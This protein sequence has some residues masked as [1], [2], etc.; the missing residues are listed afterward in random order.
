MSFFGKLKAKLFRSS[1]KL[2]K[3]ID[4]LIEEK[5]EKSEE[6]DTVQI[7]DKTKT[8]G[9]INEQNDKDIIIEK[10]SSSIE[11]NSKEKKKKSFFKKIIEPVRKLVKK[12][13]IDD[14]LL[15]SL[16]DLLIS[17]D[18][19][20][21]TAVRVSSK[22]SEK[23]AGK[24]VG[25]SEIKSLLSEVIEDI[26]EPV[27]KPLVL[28]D[29]SPQV[30][31][32]VGVNGSGKTT[33]IG[34]LA[35]QYKKLNK[36]VM[37]A[38]CDTYRAAAVEQLAIWGQRAGVPVVVGAERAD[39]AS[40]A[41]EAYERASKEGIDL[42]LIDTAGRL[43][44]KKDLMAELDKIVRVLKKKNIDAPHNRLIVLDATTGQNAINQV[45]EFSRICDL[46]GIIMTKLDGTARGGVLVAI[47]EKFSLPVHF[48]GVGETI[49]DL[50]PFEPRDFANAITGASTESL[51]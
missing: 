33:T 40:L 26:L 6:L 41:F 27:A 31:L 30:I 3:D 20:V 13:K 39:P 4:N 15:E 32:I 50:Q 51:T 48:I 37:V 22:L 1:S 38:A 14:E 23:F 8:S 28:S 11:A 18:L 29:L 17:A 47:A 9:I 16:E 19:G 43:Q 42:L 46:T 45:S 5:K 25:T 21:N 10:G 44:N 12:R 7:I 35:D 2:D 49:D 34:K 36:N 24:E